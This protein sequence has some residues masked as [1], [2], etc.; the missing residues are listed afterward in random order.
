MTATPICYPLG[1][2]NRRRRAIIHPELQDKPTKTKP[3]HNNLPIH[4]PTAQIYNR[5]FNKPVVDHDV[6]TQDKEQVQPETTHLKPTWG[7]VSD[8]MEEMWTLKRA[9]PII[10]D[11]DDEDDSS[12]ASSCC[13]PSPS[14]R[15]RKTELFASDRLPDEPFSIYIHSE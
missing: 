11:S 13:S 9:N 2:H 1:A 15:Q 14:K 7:D 10:S 8:E 4:R 5:S 12:G 6:P 3:H